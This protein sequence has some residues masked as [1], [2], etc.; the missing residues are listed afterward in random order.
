MAGCRLA[1]LELQLLQRQAAGAAAAAAAELERREQRHQRTRPLPF[2]PSSPRPRLALVRDLPHAS[3]ADARRRLAAA[4]V[5]LCR[6]SRGPVVL[7]AT[8]AGGRAGAGGG[9]GLSA[10]PAPPFLFLSLS[11]R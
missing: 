9:R 11:G 5:A 7:V 6:G 2:L 8:D 1:P 4:L 10:A 3:G